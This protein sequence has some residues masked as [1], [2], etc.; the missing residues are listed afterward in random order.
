MIK[1]AVFQLG[2]FAYLEIEASA[3][4]YD[5][6]LLNENGYPARIAG[7]LVGAKQPR[8][9]GRTSPAA[10][11]PRS[12]MNRLAA[13]FR[14]KPRTRVQSFGPI[15]RNM[16]A[17]ARRI[18]KPTPWRLWKEWRTFWLSNTNPIRP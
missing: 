7:K 17:A 12:T 11:P 3:D 10:T 9:D 16:M 2:E 13:T 18:R 1:K 4:G 8:I 6:E 5:W 14:S 15:G